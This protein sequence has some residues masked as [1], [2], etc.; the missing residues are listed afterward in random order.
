MNFFIS[1]FKHVRW[2]QL[3]RYDVIDQTSG[4][5][6]HLRPRSILVVKL[7]ARPTVARTPFLSRYYNLPYT[8][9]DCTRSRNC[10]STYDNYLARFRNKNVFR[11]DRAASP[12][13]WVQGRRNRTWELIVIISGF[14]TSTPFD[15]PVPTREHVE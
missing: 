2:I 7:S 9:Q 15:W 5:A 1:R 13:S 14:E 8:V 3:L 4:T 6:R 12:R 11:I 10:S